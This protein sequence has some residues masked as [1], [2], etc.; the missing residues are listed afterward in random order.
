MG[1]STAAQIALEGGI[2][3]D[4]TEDGVTPPNSFIVGDKYSFTSTAPTYSLTNLELALEGLAENDDI[5]MIHVLGTVDVAFL[6]N[7]D[8]FIQNM[9]LSKRWVRGVASVRKPNQGESITDYTSFLLNTAQSFYSKNIALC[10]QCEKLLLA[11]ILGSLD[12][13]LTGI[14]CDIAGVDTSGRNFTL[15][16]VRFGKDGYKIDKNAGDG[17]STVDFTIIGDVSFSST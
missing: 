10:R 1:T 14:Y 13:S 2:T 16:N 7:F 12:G 6:N 5:R 3:L 17:K 11:E 15:Q 8:V 4:V 9:G